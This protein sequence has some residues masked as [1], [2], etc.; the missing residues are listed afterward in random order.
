MQNKIEFIT[1]ETLTKVKPD[2]SVLETDAAKEHLTTI[3]GGKGKCLCVRSPYHPDLEN[4]QFDHKVMN[5]YRTT[6]MDLLKGENSFAMITAISSKPIYDE[7]VKKLLYMLNDSW[8]SITMLRDTDMPEPNIVMDLP[9]SYCEHNPM[10]WQLVVC[11]VVWTDEGYVLLR[12]YDNH[13]RLPNKVTMVQGHVEPRQEMYFMPSEKFI[14]SEFIR[15]IQEELIIEG[16]TTEELLIKSKIAGIIQDNTNAVGME[17]LGIV[18]LLDL[19]GTGIT[20]SAI[21]SNETGKHEK[22]I[23]RQ[24]DS[25]LKSEHDSWIPY[26]EK[27][28]IW[29]EETND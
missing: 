2:V 13:P 23:V 11:G 5:S 27:I 26:L 19:R 16:T 15:E 4:K 29:K 14:I 6:Y 7:Y 9:R 10:Y 12:N 22:V 1:S 8:K 28:L 17:H 21:T 18:C 25:L 3:Y 20:P 24:F